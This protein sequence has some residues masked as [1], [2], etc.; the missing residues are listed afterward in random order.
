MTRLST[1]TLPVL[2]A[3]LTLGCRATDDPPIVDMRGVN[4]GQYNVDLTEC[5]AYA[6]QVQAG[7]DVARGTVGGAVVGGAVGA[8]VGNSDTAQRAAGAGAVLGASRGARS[9][10]TERERVLRNCLRG[11][12]YRVLK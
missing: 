1:L 9:A 11:R 6:D 7:R 2:L 4:V 5:Q 10:M 12:G 8:A 3:L